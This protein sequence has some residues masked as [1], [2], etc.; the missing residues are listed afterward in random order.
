MHRCKRKWPVEATRE[1]ALGHPLLR[2]FDRTEQ[3]TGF[4]ESL[5]VLGF[6]DAIGDDA[7]ASLDVGR[8][9]VDDDR[10]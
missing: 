4:V 8:V 9:V 3:A 2:D 1:R 10:S 6:G 5:L 7:C